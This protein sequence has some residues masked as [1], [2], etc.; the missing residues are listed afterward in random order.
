MK[1]FS[2]WLV[3]VHPESIDEGW[4]QDI[5]KNKTVR[6]LVTGAALAAGSLGGVA[7]AADKSPKPVAT[8]QDAQSVT[9]ESEYD[10]DDNESI[11]DAVEEATME[12]KAKISKMYGTKVLSGIGRPVVKVDRKARKV[13]VTVTASR[14]SE[15]PAA[16][17]S[18][19]N[20]A[21]KVQRKVSRSDF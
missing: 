20:N 17:K 15:G 6:N 14:Q 3:D 21:P 2:E 12:A 8:V 10:F 13:F 16:A 19:L 18:P 1:T 7:S 5:A 4:M 9:A 11:R